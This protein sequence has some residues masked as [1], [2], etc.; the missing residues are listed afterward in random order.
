VRVRHPSARRLVRRRLILVEELYNIEFLRKLG[1]PYLNQIALLA[2]LRECPEGTMVFREGQDSPFIYFVLTG[3]VS[4]DVQE[5]DGKS[6]RVYTAVDR[7][8]F[9]EPNE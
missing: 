5:P 7:S 3:K 9:S 2:R 8:V 4:L 6:A 1:E